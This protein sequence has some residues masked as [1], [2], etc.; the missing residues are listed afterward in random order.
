LGVAAEDELADGGS[1]P[2]PDDGYLD[3]RFAGGIDEVIGGGMSIDGLPDFELH[4][5]R[6]AVGVE[7]VQVGLAR[8]GR[9][10]VCASAGGVDD[11][12]AGLAASASAK[13]KAAFPS[14][15]GR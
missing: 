5:R 12:E 2:Q 10:D 11:D 9:I 6:G 3:A 13:V 14:G 15:V 8:E 1:P 4:G 7:P